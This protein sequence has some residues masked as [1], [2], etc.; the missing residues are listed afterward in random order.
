M[1]VKGRLIR[2]IETLKESIQLGIQEKSRGVS[3]AAKHLAW[4][5]DELRQ[6]AERLDSELKK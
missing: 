6:L 4:C 3:G 5:Y 1:T 2:D